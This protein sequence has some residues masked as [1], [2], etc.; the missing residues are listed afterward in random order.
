LTGP[1]NPRPSTGCVEAPLPWE[2]RPAAMAPRGIALF[3]DS[4]AP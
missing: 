3:F 4:T 1:D 2:R